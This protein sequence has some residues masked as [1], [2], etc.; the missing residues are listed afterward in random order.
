M[1]LLYSLLTVALTLFF[2]HL[3]ASRA[4]CSGRRYWL[5]FLLCLPFGPIG[6]V[7]VFLVLEAS[8]HRREERELIGPESDKR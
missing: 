1:M 8:N 7:V 6:T 3:I 4:K 5:W 2:A